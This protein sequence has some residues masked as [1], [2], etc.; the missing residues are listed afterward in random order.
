MVASHLRRP[1]SRLRALGSTVLLHG[2]K[3]AGVGV[4]CAVAYF[5]PGNCVLPEKSCA[6]LSFLDTQ[7]G[8]AFYADAVVRKL[9]LHAQELK[10]R[11]ARCRRRR[12]PSCSE[13]FWGSESGGG[14]GRAATVRRG[15]QSRGCGTQNESSFSLPRP[16]LPSFYLYFISYPKNLSPTRSP[17]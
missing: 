16:S 9:A 12:T 8:S 15:S 6:L 1:L 5:D 3:H 2:K 11:R 4:V 10:A 7:T 17:R 14:L 13:L